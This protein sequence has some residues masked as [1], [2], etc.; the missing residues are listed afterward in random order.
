MK[1]IRVNLDSLSSLAGFDP[2]TADTWDARPVSTLRF[3][4]ILAK[5][6]LSDFT[7]GEILF[8]FTAGIHL[9][10]DDPFPEQDGNEALDMPLDLPEEDPFRLW[11]LRHKLLCIEIS[12]EDA[13]KWSWHRIVHSLREELGYNPDGGTDPLQSLGEHFFPETLS[14]HGMP[15]RH[16]GR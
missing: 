3:T 15:V 1:F 11:T 12:D 5:L 13:E 4:E 2:A 16:C 14:S 7:T 10:G 9:D 6:Y 8:L